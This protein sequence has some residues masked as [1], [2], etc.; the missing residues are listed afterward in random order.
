LSAASA[1]P[2]KEL[3]KEEKVKK[4]K[5]KKDKVKKDVPG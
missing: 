3:Q 1:S 4:E 2:L 5:V